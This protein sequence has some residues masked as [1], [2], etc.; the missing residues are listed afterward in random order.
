MSECRWRTFG[1]VIDDNFSLMLSNNVTSHSIVT[2]LLLW[3]LLLDD[4]KDDVLAGLLPTF[5]T[6][7][8]FLY[9]SSETVKNIFINCVV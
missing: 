8:T 7:K 5:T 2:L 9:G 1:G 6:K 3:P 4:V